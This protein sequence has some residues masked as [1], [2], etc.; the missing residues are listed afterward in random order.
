MPTS[1]QL[2]TGSRGRRRGAGAGRRAAGAALVVA[3]VLGGVLPGSAQG[4]D[5]GPRLT[6][7][8]ATAGPGAAARS[9]TL[10]T[11]DVVWYADDDGTG[12]G[13]RIDRIVPGPGRDGMGFTRYHVDGHEYAVP[14]DA[15]EQIATGRVDQRLFD[16]STLVADGYADADTAALRLVVG[17]APSVDGGPEAPE[18]ARLEREFSTAGA[19]VLSV[20]K[21]HAGAVWRR[22][23]TAG[24]AAK[25]AGIGKVWLDGRVRATLDESVPQIG[26]DVA[27]RQ[28]VDGKGVR[29]AVL[30]TGYD[31]GHPDLKGKVAGEADFTGDGIQ[32]VQGHGTHVS[33]TVAGSGAASAGRY[34]GVAPG[35][36]LLEGKVLDNSG[37]GYDSWIIA[38]MEWAAKEDADIVSM[39]LGKSVASDGTDPLSGAVDR[40]SADGG[41]LFVIAA[42]NTGDRTIGSPGAADSALTV[43]S[44]T[45]QGALSSFSSRGPRQGRWA[46]KPEVAAPGSAIVAARA[47]GTLGDSAV[48]ARYASLS[49]TS[50]ATPHVAG[51]AALL[52]QQH[53]DWSGQRLKAA[54]VGTAAPVAGTTV[55]QTGG[56]LVDVPASFAAKVTAEPATLAARAAGKPETRTVTWHNDG[57][58]PVTL[59]VSAQG[60]LIG[61]PARTVTVPAG[62][63]ATSTVRLDLAGAEP[64]GSYGGTVT[65]DWP[66][67]GAVHVPVSVTAPDDA[68]TLTL[69][70]PAPRAGTEATQTGVVIQNEK[71]GATTMTS[72]TGT[73]PRSVTLPR[74]TYR[75][76]GHTWEYDKAGTTITAVTAVHHARRVTVDGDASVTLGTEAAR[77]VRIGVDDDGVR[78][79]TF[80]ATGIGTT[81]PDGSATGLVATSAAGPYRVQ[82]V[83]TK[84]GETFDGMRFFAGTS[85]QQREIDAHEP[86]RPAQ[87]LGLQLAQYSIYRW[88]GKVTAGV[89]DI[90]GGSDAELAGKDLNGKIVLWRPATSQS[91]VNNAVY[92]KLTDAG[93][94]LILLQG[95]G[96]SVYRP[97]PIAS[98]N[99]ES[100]PLLKDRLAQGPLTL[101]VE[102]V[103][104]SPTAYF[105][106]HKQDGTLPAGA[107]WYDRRADLARIDTT[108]NTHGYPSDPKGLYAWTTWQGVRLVQQT[109]RFR[110]PSRQQV[111]VSPD[112]AWSMATFHYQ[113]D[114]GERPYALGTQVTDPTTYAKGRTYKESW[115]AAPFNP[116]LRGGEHVV[117]DGDKLRIS[118]PAF[119]DE[120]GHHSETAPEADT[121]STVLA[122]DRG[123]V[124]DS[125]DRPGQ[126]VFDL[127]RDDRWYRLT[128]DATRAARD[129]VTWTLGTRVTDEWRLRS[130]HER[131]ASPARLI[132]L[133]YDTPLDGLDTTDP[134]EELTYTVTAGTQ[135]GTRAR[136]VKSLTVAYSTDDGATWQ[137]ARTHRD[138]D[139]WK[140]TVPAAGPAKVSLRTTVTDV[141][142]ASLTET[143]I[144]AYNSGCTDIWCGR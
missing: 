67:R 82:V 119:S 135:G 69:T 35:A 20:P 23:A 19:A 100:A 8:A 133:T 26:A 59:D 95:Y 101:T 15:A 78:T 127:P 3:A 111:Y 28:G 7:P 14:I 138:G 136:P 44:V 105:L 48:N 124:L 132:D 108:G 141:T 10:L 88:T 53:P 130:G 74:G 125:N 40:L 6:D 52:R 92:Q 121:G 65:A 2:P 30:D 139:D 68:R 129:Q 97:T 76:T 66:G 4:A 41:P 106:F 126:A 25:N 120:A 107:D 110:A 123:A 128:V 131:K 29:V 98:L 57:D 31:T 103:D 93:V 21:K 58:R 91:A 77:P 96:V 99:A 144:K 12:G 33:S 81:T 17:D 89:V 75:L 18:H 24:A 137:Q 63:T 11:G 70:G 140:V 54:L 64:G 104:T 83:P 118:L 36:R 51:A 113:F 16:V 90:G 50:M 117:R 115:L 142:G 5:D 32:D 49:G 94:S 39:S 1:R 42:G 71:T 46:V 87:E 72:L 61:V 84:D 122:D 34:A 79:T 38:G 9:V 143:L 27:H 134:D 62:G 55:D 60:A 80:G 37:S 85:W 56:G 86:G 116:E 43:G 109:T 47:A 102:G 73:T 22:L 112:V 45:K 13:P 114:V